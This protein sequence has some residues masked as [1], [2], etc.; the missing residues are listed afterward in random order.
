MTNRKL[1]VVGNGMV[2]HRFLELTKKY[3]LA[4]E[5]DIYSIGAEPH[6]AY[7]RVALSSY[8]KSNDPN[9]LY[10]AQSDFYDDFHY[11]QNDA[12]VGIDSES[13]VV[14]TQSGRSIA[15][16]CLVLATGSKPFVPPIPGSNSQGCFVYRTFEDIDSIKVAALSSTSSKGIVVGGGLLGLEAAEVLSYY[17]METHII[18]L[19]PRLMSLQIDEAGGNVLSQRVIELGYSVHLGTSVSKIVTDPDGRVVGAQLSDGQYIETEVIVF[20]TG[21]RAEHALAISGGLEVGAR[22]GFAVNSHCETSN[23]TI[24]A[25]GECASFDGRTYGLVA[26]GYAMADVVASRLTGETNEFVSGDL[27]TKLKLLGV[28]VASFGDAFGATPGALDVVFVDQIRG[29]YKKLVLSDDAK[30]LLGGIMVGDATNYPLLRSLAASK[31]GIEGDPEQYMISSNSTPIGASA[32]SDNVNVCSCHNVEAGTIRQCIIDEGVCEISGIKNATKA[33]TG[34]GSCLPLVKDILK[35]QLLAEGKEVSKALCEH[36]TYSRQELFDLIRIEEIKTFSL[37]IESHGTGRGCDICK[38]T[39]A[40]ILASTFGAHPLEAE[41]AG[42]QD[43]NDH[44]LANIQKNGTYSVIPRIPG[45]EV[46]P[47]GLLAIAQVAKDFNL[48]TKITGAQR[49][50]LLGARAEQLPQI[51][52]RLIEAGFESGQA[53]GKA[54][55]TVKS[56]V[57]STWCRYG[58][59]DSVKMAIELELRYRGLRSP[60]KLKFGVSGCARECAEARSKDVGVIATDRGWNMYVGGNGGFTPR[61]AELFASDIDTQTLIR[62]V[63]RFIMYYIR[64]ADRL[65]RTATWIQSIE[66]GLDHVKEVVIQDSLGLS[67]ELES[68]VATHVDKYQDEWNLVLEDPVK[69]Q[70]FSSF[71]NAPAQPDPSIEFI[72]ERA[73]PRPTPVNLLAKKPNR[74]VSVDE[75]I[76]VCKQEDLQ[77][78]RPHAAI[79]HGYQLAIVMHSDGRIYAVENFDPFSGANVLS[80]GLIG[81]KEDRPVII[82]PMYRHSF[83]LTNGKCIEDESISIGVHSVRVR[84]GQVEISG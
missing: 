26:P 36:F 57:G 68:A 30:T 15:F 19:A 25:I 72:T 81:S 14:T 71:V 41:H 49:I 18:E 63:D 64:S 67:G 60:H 37:L 83:D 34:C 7:D 9:E 55:R 76:P 6:F 56:C 16:D 46:T 47:D 78:Q 35:E 65:Q 44:L 61:H 4:Q 38:P 13:K 27:S 58:V 40:S 31:K 24:Y 42:I 22:G 32:L 53:Y 8:T 43:T 62:Y 59:Q 5:Y 21:V 82:S 74:E 66:G 33:G 79:V 54:V 48:Y 29:V 52:K 11:I 69:L 39:I 75:W 28:D 77:M 80:R 10:L 84:D 1:V 50:D 17:G 3:D 51:W 12:V 23:P 45:G 20:A 2:G 70:Y 73:Q